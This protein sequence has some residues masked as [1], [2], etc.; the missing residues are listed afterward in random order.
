MNELSKRLTAHVGRPAVILTL[1]ELASAT[2]PRGGG[3]DRDPVYTATALR[4][5][6][7]EVERDTPAS[8]IERLEERGITLQVPADRISE[9]A[10]PE[11][12]RQLNGIQEEG[13]AV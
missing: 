4:A 11:L 6:A 2:R 13:R 12:E 8:V 7:D 1:R 3:P 5:L 9:D 10:V